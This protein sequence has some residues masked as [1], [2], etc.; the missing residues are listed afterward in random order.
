MGPNCIPPQRDDEAVKDPQSDIINVSIGAER[1]IT[2]ANNDGDATELQVLK[3]R[4][5]IVSSRFVQDFWVHGIDPFHQ[6]F[7]EIN[8]LVV[9]NREE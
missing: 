9:S 7:L 6:D 3:D 5:V 8:F 1:T 4:S 2:F